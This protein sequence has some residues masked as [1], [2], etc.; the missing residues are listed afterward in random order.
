MTNSNIVTISLIVNV[1]SYVLTNWLG[2]TIDNAVI[3]TTIET[4]V[5]VGT[6]IWALIA[7]KKVV[8]VAV[9]NGVAKG[10]L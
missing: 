6:A 5:I 7:H 9:A 4:V 3:T 1:V 10:V 8:A 2:L